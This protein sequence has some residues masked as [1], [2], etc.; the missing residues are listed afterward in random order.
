MKIKNVVQ[1]V[2]IFM[3]QFSASQYL[4][5]FYS[6]PPSKYPNLHIAARLKT[7][8]SL[9]RKNKKKQH[10]PTHDGYGQKKNRCVSTKIAFFWNAEKN[11]FFHKVL[12][13]VPKL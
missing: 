3:S 4:N 10:Y 1:F 11:A 5:P 7:Y 13:C 9:D 8:L 6:Y 2:I 12:S